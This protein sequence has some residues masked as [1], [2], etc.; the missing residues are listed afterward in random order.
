MTPDGNRLVVGVGDPNTNNYDEEGFAIVEGFVRVYELG[1][2]GLMTQ[3]GN[4]INGISSYKYTGLSVNISD[5]GNLFENNSGTVRVYDW[6]PENIT[7]WIQVA[8]KIDGPAQVPEPNTLSQMFGRPI[9]LSSN[10][11]RLVISC[12]RGFNDAVPTAGF[13]QVFSNQ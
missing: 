6:N 8:N 3:V 9:D 7:D 11:N 10:G 5:D 1:E 4:D 12:T 2:T 13:V